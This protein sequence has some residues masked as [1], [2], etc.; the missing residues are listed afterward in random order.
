MEMIKLTKGFTVSNKHKRS[1]D[2]GR[3]LDLFGFGE[4]KGGEF[5]CDINSIKT[6]PELF[7]G[8]IDY[9]DVELDEV[10][11]KEIEDVELDVVELKKNR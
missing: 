8:R 3:S 4:T 7:K 1:K 5:F 10:K 6:H 9:I 2:K 11:F